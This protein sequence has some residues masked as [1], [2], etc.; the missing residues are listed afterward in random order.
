MML[1]T[2]NAGSSSLRL[3]AFSAAGADIEAIAATRFDLHDGSV[4]PLLRHFVNEHKLNGV[5]AVVHRIVHGGAHFSGACKVDRETE[6]KL[7]ELAPLAPL[8]SEQSLALIRTARAVFGADTPQVASFDTAFYRNLP[9]IASHYALPAELV[10]RHGLRRYGFHGLAHEAL[11]QR[12]SELEANGTNKGRIL[13]L[14][15]GSGCSITA[16]HDGRPV[17]TSMGF[18]PMEGLMM[19][20]RCGDVDAGLL[21]YLQQYQG[22]SADELNDLLN[23]HSGLLGVSG[24]SADMRMLLAADTA[25]AEL[26][27]GLYCYRVRK[28]IGAYLAALG[29]AQSI[30]FGGGVGENS[31]EIRAR[32][33]CDMQWAGIHLDP[34]LNQGATG[35]EQRISTQSSPVSVWVLKVDEQ[36]LMARQA[37]EL[38]GA[39]P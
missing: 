27:V 30:V 22:L 29:G 36:Q 33:L 11:W 7:T 20:T 32:I 9:Q 25:E 4:E 13:T 26:A 15:L 12:W 31:A 24:L 16:T 21:L 34:A 17:D 1:L 3:A 19:A 10:A 6:R 8:H 5:T 37:M 14:Q 18:T 38:L 35:Q 28:Y 39:Q 23:R 2:A